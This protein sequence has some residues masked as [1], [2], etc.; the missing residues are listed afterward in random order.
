MGNLIKDF[1]TYLYKDKNYFGIIEVVRGNDISQKRNTVKYET[2]IEKAL[3]YTFKNDV[4]SHMSIQTFSSWLKSRVDRED[5]EQRYYPF[6]IEFEPKKEKG[7]YEKAVFEA[8]QYVNY[9]QTK[10]EIKQEDILIMVNNSKSIYVSINPKSYACKPHARLN[11]IYYEM[12]LQIS[13]SLNLE[14]TDESIVGS[15]YKLMKTPNTLYN[16]GYFV[17]IS[18]DELMKLAAG[19]LTKGELTK[20]KRSLD[21]E[22]PGELSINAAKLFNN[23][24]KK[25]LYNKV[26]EKDT[27]EVSKFKS[28]CGGKCIQYF[29]THLMDEGYRNYGLVSVGIYLK[30]LGY[31]KEE[32]I[33]NLLELGK[34]WQ[35]DESERGIIAKVNTIYR[36]N[37]NFSCKYAKRIF[38]GMDIDNMCSNC[39]FAKKNIENS[40]TFQIDAD[41]INQL[42]NKKGSTRHYLMYLELENRDLFN[43]NIN[44]EEEKINERT[45][46]E[47]CKVTNLTLHKVEG[48][49]G[50]FKIANSF[51]G[52]KYRLKKEFIEESA[53]SLGESLKHY[54]KLL[55]KGYRSNSKYIMFKASMENLME[56]LR[57][58]N[59]SSL[60]KLLTKLNALGL[61]KTHKKSVYTLYYSSFKVVELYSQSEANIQENIQLNKAVGEQITFSNLNNN[62]NIEKNEGLNKETRE[63]SSTKGEKYGNDVK[64]LIVNGLRVRCHEELELDES[65]L[66]FIKENKSIIQNYKRLY[67]HSSSSVGKYYFKFKPIDL[68]DWIDNIKELKLSRQMIIF[69]SRKYGYIRNIDYIFK[70]VLWEN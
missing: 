59:K 12:Y 6:I 7:T 30:S 53:A 26:E 43:K 42:W 54:L 32:T 61:I 60:Y 58:E 4:I 67:I 20:V 19:S 48:V 63:N 15:M 2:H 39:P 36:K 70:R 68:E 51:D 31:T 38:S 56:D 37:Y 11:E 49:N 41:I 66:N 24:K 13:K 52:N 33:K 23:A 1:W 25:V 3:E 46:K 17:R 18:A 47:L 8:V 50:I 64:E 9:L 57:Y 22:V 45:L 69:N 34:L 5:K 27:E 10:L 35:H 44:L 65:L 29:L 40:N 16:G 62:I 28:M 14:Q 21:I 55:I